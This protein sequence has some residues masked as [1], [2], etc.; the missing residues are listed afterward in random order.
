MNNIQHQSNKIPTQRNFPNSNI[1]LMFDNDMNI[2][3]RSKLFNSYSKVYILSNSLI[4]NE[5]DLSEKV[6]KFKQSLIEKISKLIPNSLVLK[7]NE[8]ESIL[9]DQSCIDVIYP[10]VG[11]NLDLI[12]RYTNQNQIFINFI[13][14]EEDLRYWHYANSGFY[15]FKT[16]FYTLNNIFNHIN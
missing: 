1:L 4:N 14:R 7:C 6:I 12:K 3:N 10:G 13:Y 11:Q 5:F 9:Y 2:L 8:L 16:S 15:K